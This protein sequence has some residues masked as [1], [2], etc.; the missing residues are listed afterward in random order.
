MK[1]KYIIYYAGYGKGYGISDMLGKTI[2]APKYFE[3]KHEKGS[4]FCLNYKEKLKDEDNL[5]KYDVETQMFIVK[6]KKSELFIPSSFD[7]CSNFN[8]GLAIAAIN[9]KFGIVDVDGNICINCIYD[10]VEL[11]NYKSIIVKK[12]GKCSLMDFDEKKSLAVYN[13]ILYLADKYFL[14][15]EHFVGDYGILNDGGTIIIPAKYNYD[16]TSVS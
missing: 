10:K 4:I 8:E 7:W 9:H 16:I 12:D 13:D 15:Q 1:D 2:L 5:I 6:N 14:F 11:G 3:I